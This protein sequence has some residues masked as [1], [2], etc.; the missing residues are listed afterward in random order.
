MDA[1]LNP[2]EERA[3]QRGKIAA[4]IGFIL[5]VV[6]LLIPIFFKLNPPPGQPGI[7]VLLAFDDQGSGNDPAGPA[8]APT[9]DPTPTPP[10]PQPEP[11]TPPPPPPAPAEPVKKPVVRD[12]VQ[13]ETPQE[14]AIRKRKEQEQARKQEADRK[15]REE[16]DQQ[17]REQE[18]ADR[19]ER[20]RIAR[21]QQA[22]RERQA[23]IDEANRKAEEDRKR[24]QANADRFRTSVGGSLEGGTEGRGDSN[25]SGTEGSDDGIRQGGVTAGTG[26]RVSGGLGG[27]GLLSSPAVRDASQRSGTVVVDVCVDQNGN[28]VSAKKTLSGTT[29]TDATLIN[30][31]VSNAKKWRFKADPTAPATQ[32]GRITYNFKVQ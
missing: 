14:I 27:R 25:Q 10:Q 7:A 17:R 20:E 3:D 29:T 13:A 32:C 9:P 8:P 24:R 26:G 18:A 22:E 31:A 21:E 1:Q 6:L 28:V 5:L 15:R 16:A 12:V 19:A 4:G 23:A 11:A 2:I 30:S